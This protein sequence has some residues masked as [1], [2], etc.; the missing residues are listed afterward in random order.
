MLC[1]FGQAWHKQHQLPMHS[2]LAQQIHGSTNRVTSL[3]PQFSKFK[4]RIPRFCKKGSPIS[5]LGF[6]LLRLQKK[7]LTLVRFL[8][9][10]S[11]LQ[12]TNQTGNIT[13]YA[14]SM[15]DAGVVVF[16]CFQ[17]QLVSCWWCWWWSQWPHE[18]CKMWSFF[19]RPLLAE[20][21]IY[22]SFLKLI[23][24]STLLASLPSVNDRKS[25]NSSSASNSQTLMMMLAKESINKK[26]SLLPI[27][28]SF[29]DYRF[30]KSGGRFVPIPQVWDGS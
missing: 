10:K 3:F 9:Q 8:H 7:L 17:K 6:E 4:T 29:F 11:T 25:S 19:C 24:P 28:M 23:L 2:C 27:F 18:G 22:I 1:A 15:L 16:Q 14:I 30:L 12:W 21:M 13:G 26:Q 5:Y 20:A